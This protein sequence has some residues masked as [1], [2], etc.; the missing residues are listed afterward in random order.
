MQFLW[1]A[2]L[3]ILNALVVLVLSNLL[4]FFPAS[5]WYWIA[6]LILWLAL[7]M[8]WRQKKFDTLL[9]HK[10]GEVS[11]LTFAFLTLSIFALR[12]FFVFE[13]ILAVYLV[14]LWY[15]SSIFEWVRQEGAFRVVD[16]ARLYWGELIAFFFALVGI[17]S[18]ATFFGLGLYAP[19]ILIG[20]VSLLTFYFFARRNNI[21]LSTFWFYFSLWLVILFELLFVVFPWQRGVFFKAFL[22]FVIYYLYAEFIRHFRA[23]NLTL[24]L[25]FQQLLFGMVL[26][27]ILLLFDWLFV[28][29]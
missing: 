13:L 10:L 19:M 26:L 24:K 27:A 12:S 18:A 21:E 1:Q 6:L 11:L 14:S 29:L 8:F 25:A 2:R 5:I 9:L 22:I 20:A 15:L 28:L 16:M 17:L 23:G 7:S 4:Y 3:K